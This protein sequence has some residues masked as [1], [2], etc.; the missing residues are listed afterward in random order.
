MAAKVESHP[1][2]IEELYEI[3]MASVAASVGKR[4]TPPERSGGASVCAILATRY[5]TGM[6]E[7]E[8]K[9]RNPV[10]WPLRLGA[11]FLGATMGAIFGPIAVILIRCLVGLGS[12][13]PEILECAKVSAC[14]GVVTGIA[15]P[16]RTASISGSLA[17]LLAFLG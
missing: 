5:N 16:R 11:V 2:S 4:Q 15:F 8:A 13:L 1:W 6:N 10:G 7:S 17:W 14:I 3:V 9:T 12:H